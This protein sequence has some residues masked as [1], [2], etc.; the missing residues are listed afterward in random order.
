MEN[1]KEKEIRFQSVVRDLNTGN[2]TIFLAVELDKEEQEHL[3][4]IVEKGW[5]EFRDSGKSDFCRDGILKESVCR[6]LIE[7]G[8]LESDDE[9]WH[10]TYNITKLGKVVANKLKI[11]L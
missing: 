9:S 6:K 10:I 11:N 8:L 2:S 4:K 5:W 1:Y 7:V 3:I